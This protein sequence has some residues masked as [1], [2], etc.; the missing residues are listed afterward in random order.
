MRNRPALRAELATAL[1]NA[2]AREWEERLLRR[3]VPAG[4]VQSVGAGLDLAA[5]LGLQPFLDVVDAAG[6]VVGRQVRGPVTLHPSP[7]PP[8][9]A[10]PRLGEHD[11]AVRAWLRTS[12]PEPAQERTIR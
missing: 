5:Q 1:R 11:D 6:A 7:P 10:P 8:R 9:G 12:A 3:G 4:R 2:S